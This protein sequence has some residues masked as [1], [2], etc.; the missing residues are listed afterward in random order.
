MDNKSIILGKRRDRI[1]ASFLSFKEREC[2]QFLPQEIS[3]KLRKK[4]LDD[5]ND[6]CDIAFDLIA[7]ETVVWNDEFMNRL[8]DIYQMVLDTKSD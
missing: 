6:L 5:I 8:D 7:D 4:F 1:I 2:D 3:S